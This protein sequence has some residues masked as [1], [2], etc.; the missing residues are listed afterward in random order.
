MKPHK[1]ADWVWVESSE[2]WVCSMRVEPDLSS[3]VQSVQR[4]ANTGMLRIN[5]FVDGPVIFRY[6][7]EAWTKLTIVGRLDEL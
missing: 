1:H 7:N 6:T 4:Y 2:G 3:F 5:V